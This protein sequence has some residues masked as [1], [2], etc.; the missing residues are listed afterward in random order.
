MTDD[1]GILQHAVFTVPNLHHGYCVDDNAR[2][3]IV[4]CLDY[5]VRK[6]DTTLPLIQKYLAFLHYGYNLDNGRFRNFMSYDRTWLEASGSED[7]HSQSL[8]GLG[9]AIRYAPNHGLMNMAKTIFLDALP[10]VSQFVHP[11]PWAFS[12]I[13]LDH[14]LTMVPNDEFPTQLYRHLGNQLLDRFKAHTSPDWIWC[15]DRLTYANAKLPHA[16]ILCGNR[17]KNMEMRQV[18][19]DS[20]AW[21]FKIQTA[22]EGQLSIVGNQDWFPKGDQKSTFAQQPIEAMSLIDAAVDAYWITQ[23]ETWMDNAKLCL[24]WFQG[25]NDIH[26]PLY[27]METGGCHDGLEAS[28]VNINQGAESTL[29]WL[30]ALLRLYQG[31]H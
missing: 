10:V 19:L 29:S 13:G 26:T 28:G 31:T 18:G 2:A 27:N 12:I 6:D 5:H 24:A 14:Y 4:A 25:F 30:L 9:T 22:K 16:L 8:W 21:L 11:R 20:L 7:S 23:D 1:T 3:L 17:L 15:A